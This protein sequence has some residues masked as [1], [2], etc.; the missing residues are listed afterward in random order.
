[1]LGCNASLHFVIPTGAQRSGGICSFTLG[2]SQCAM[3]NYLRVLSPPRH[4]LQI[5][6]L[7]CA[8]VGMTKW[9]LAL[10]PS[11]GVAGWTEP[12]DKGLLTYRE[13]L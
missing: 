2:H 10:H 7:R 8:P 13:R 5:P 12:T 4:K 3:A 1:M 9:R 6:P 11:I